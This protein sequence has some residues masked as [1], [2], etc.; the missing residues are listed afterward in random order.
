LYSHRTPGLGVGGGGG[1][2]PFTA[3]ISTNHDPLLLV[4]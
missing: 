1:G 4:I 2:L 3:A